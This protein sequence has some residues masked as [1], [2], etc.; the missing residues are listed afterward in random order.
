MYAVVELSGKQWIVAQGDKIIVDRLSEEKGATITL[1][2]ILL[3]FDAE[4]KNVKVGTP[5]LSKAEVK[6]TI[7]DHTK[8][9]KIRSV[10]FQ[11][12]KRYHKTKGFRQSQTVLSIESISV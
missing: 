11:G 12:K 3:G 9:D 5:Y 1:D 4:G 8:G 6:A 10:K 2:Q 7:V